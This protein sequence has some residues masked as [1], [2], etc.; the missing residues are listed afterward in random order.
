M[1]LST[2]RYS[3]VWNV[4]SECDFDR[5]AVGSF[6]G[7][8]GDYDLSPFILPRSFPCDSRWIDVERPLVS[9]S[10]RMPLGDSFAKW[11]FFEFQPTRQAPLNGHHRHRWLTRCYYEDELAFFSFSRF[12]RHFGA[13]CVCVCVCV[14]AVNSVHGIDNDSV[15]IANEMILS[16]RL[17]RRPER[18]STEKKWHPTF[19]FGVE[20]L[21][22][23]SK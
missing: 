7:R 12:A 17:P 2:S 15:V 3:S 23:A 14:P 5:L 8:I 13:V 20:T 1:R 11:T 22:T 9:F 21:L 4:I 18:Q 6:D 19:G 10:S 16:A